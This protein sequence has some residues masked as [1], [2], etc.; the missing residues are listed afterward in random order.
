M[1]EH[2]HDVPNICL[3]AWQMATNFKLPPDY[4]RV[5]KV[6]VLGMGGSA[7]GADLIGNL[8]AGR[9]PSL[10]SFCTRALW[11]MASPESI[12]H[13]TKTPRM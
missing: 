3:Q 8:V 2:I 4:S 11:N 12:Y 10:S 13:L 6:V 7:I 9:P 1:L 5:N